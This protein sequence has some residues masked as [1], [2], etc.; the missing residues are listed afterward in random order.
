[1][2][3]SEAL[4]GLAMAEKMRCRAPPWTPSGAYNAPRSPILDLT[5]A[6]HGSE[7]LKKWAW[8]KLGEGR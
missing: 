4:P 8:E 5:G 6:L 7:G 2:K 1:M 3:S